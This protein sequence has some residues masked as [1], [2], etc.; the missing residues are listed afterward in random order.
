MKLL[1]PVK[2]V[3][4][5][6][7]EFELRDDGRDVDPDFL[8][9]DLN[10]FDDYSLEEAVKLKEAGEGIEVVA[11]TV[12]PDEADDVLRKCLA[13]GA[14]RAI[15]IWDEALEGSDSTVIARLL[16]AVVAREKPDLIFT[17]AQSADHGFAQTGIALAG[18]LGWAH[19]AVVSFLD[20]VADGASAKLRRELEGGPRG[21]ELIE[22]LRGGLFLG[23]RFF[24]AVESGEGVVGAAHS[25]QCLGN[26]ALGLRGVFARDQG[27]GGALGFVDLAFEF[28]NLLLQRIAGF[29][30][31]VDRSLHG[32]DLLVAFA[33]LGE[34][35]T[36]QIFVVGV[37][38]LPRAIFPFLRLTDVFLIFRVQ[39]VI[40]AHRDS[41]RLHGF[42]Q[43][44]LHVGDGLPDGGVE[45]SVFDGAHTFISLAAGDAAGAIKNIV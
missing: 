5:L 7:D 11:V 24:K 43:L 21:G 9:F 17:G 8:E 45:C 31:L 25:G 19:V 27:G 34:S 2:R 42:I 40:V 32:C 1:V 16:A 15:R 12:G 13:K 22:G 35:F 30:R 29:L 38:R 20:V 36:G 28:A 18:L 10:E 41:G 14:D 39:A 26:F 37:E 44:R 3:G 4:V 6:D 23:Y 33:F